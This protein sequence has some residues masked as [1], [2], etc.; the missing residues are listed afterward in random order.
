[1]AS[2]WET[3]QV[4]NQEM[5]VYS[6]VPAGSG[7]FPTVLIA[8]P[9]SGVGEFTQSIADRLAEDGFA[10]IAMDLFHRVTDDMISDGTAKN[11]FLDDIEICLLYTS[12]AA[13]E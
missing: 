3:L 10:G 13:D 5:S 4:D 11:A 2:F 6:S 8:H 9:A 1:M 7:P 12:D